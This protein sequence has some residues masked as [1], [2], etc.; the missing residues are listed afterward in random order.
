MSDRKDTGTNTRVLIVEDHEIMRQ[1]L[2]TLVEQEEDLCV[3]G[4]AEDASAALEAAEQLEPDVIVLDLSL[5]DSNGLDLIKDLRLRKPDLPIIVLTMHDESFYAERAL[6]S[7]ARGYVTKSEA[8]SRII[9]GIREVLSGGVYVSEKMASRMVRKM[10]TGG[11]MGQGYPIDTLTD[12]EFEIFEMIG[13][14]LPV[15]EIAK[16]LHLSVRTVEAHRDHMRKKLNLES[17]NDLLR[18]ATQWRQF[19]GS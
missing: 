2:S 14:G 15:R 6:R 18:Y 4:E 11:S 12:R 16:R 19:E 5:R 1:G 7:G 13:R 10:V 9:E 17:A 3:C 8:S